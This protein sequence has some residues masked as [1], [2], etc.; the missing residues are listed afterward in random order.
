MEVNTSGVRRAYVY[1]GAKLV[2]QQSA[3]GQFYWLHTN[4]LGSARAMTDVSGNL[5]YKGQFDP[6]GQS[7]SEWSSSGATNLNTKKFTGY[8]RDATGLDYAGAR[9]YNSG[10]GRFMQPDPSGLKWVD[11]RSPESLNSYSYVQNDPINFT[12]STGMNREYMDGA[13]RQSDGTCGI[14]FMCPGIHSSGSSNGEG[15]NTSYWWVGGTGSGGNGSGSGQPQVFFD[16]PN[17]NE[18]LTELLSQEL[19]GQFVDK[20]HAYLGSP[21]PLMTV[22]GWT[23]VSMQAAVRPDGRVAPGRNFYEQGRM[24]VYITPIVNENP[25]IPGGG[26]PDERRDAQYKYATVLVHELLHFNT[27]G[28]QNFSHT[29]FKDAVLSFKD[30]LFNAI[31]ADLQNKVDKGKLTQSEAE[32]QLL[33]EAFKLACPKL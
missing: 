9:M 23:T 21:Y 18:Y 5:V 14:G 12:D 2:A 3:D 19:C 29:D 17:W 1:A 7:L 28:S 32:T 20:I 27:F 4:H 25:T 15:V 10:R 11:L 30:D 16:P 33:E 31:Y 24:E 26:L 22:L 13:E 6:Y 8:E